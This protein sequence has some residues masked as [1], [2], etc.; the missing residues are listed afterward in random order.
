MAACW[1]VSKN[2]DAGMRPLGR[3]ASLFLQSSLSLSSSLDSTLSLMGFLIAFLHPLIVPFP[4]FHHLTF[5]YSFQNNSYKPPRR[6][7]RLRQ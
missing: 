7:N 2:S 3:V 6:S 4:N 1:G 5:L